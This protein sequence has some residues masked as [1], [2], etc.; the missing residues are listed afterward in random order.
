V[1]SRKHST[2]SRWQLGVCDDSAQNELL[3]GLC[4]SGIVLCAVGHSGRRLDLSLCHH[5]GN[6]REIPINLLWSFCRCFTRWILGQGWSL[7]RVMLLTT[8]YWVL[9]VV[10][11]KLLFEYSL[12]HFYFFIIGHKVILWWFLGL[13]FPCC[14][15][16]KNFKWNK[17]VKALCVTSGIWPVNY[18]VSSLYVFLSKLLR[19]CPG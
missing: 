6:H 11:H 8:V 3:C 2:S 12:T 15:R 10:S 4:I 7:T 17:I 16:I 14:S 5:C 9:I 19:V 1:L 13:I 18:Y